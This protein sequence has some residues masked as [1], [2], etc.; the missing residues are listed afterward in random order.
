MVRNFAFEISRITPGKN[1][2]SRFIKR[3]KNKIK[4]SYL[5]PA[6]IARKWADNPY[7]YKLFYELL[8]E[9]IEKYEIEVHNMYNMDKKGFL[10]SVLNKGK[11]IYTKSEAVRGKLLG[12]SQ[13]GNREWITIIASVYADGTSLPPGLNNTGSS[14]HLPQRVRQ[15]T[16]WD[17]HGLLPSLI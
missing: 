16:R 1:W 13:D 9:K 7:Q 8:K 11:R 3:H 15:T 12:A 6:N 10:I 4:S 14:S 5:A 17:S 2:V